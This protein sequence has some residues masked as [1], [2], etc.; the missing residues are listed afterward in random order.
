MTKAAAKESDVFKKKSSDKK[1]VVGKSVTKSAAKKSEVSKK[2]SPDKK[3]VV[4]KSVT[5]ETAKKSESSKKSS[6]KKLGSKAEALKE[7]VAGKKPAIKKAENKKL[8]KRQSKKKTAG[9]GLD[10]SLE[11]SKAWQNLKEKYEG[12][13]IVSYNMKKSFESE[14]AIKHK[15]FGLG[16]IISQYNNRLEVLFKDGRKKLISN[17]QN[18]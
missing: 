10:S 11:D 14:I 4:G 9:K 13:K 12:G 7:P 18:N 1:S 8:T 5:K 17:Y 6:D 16:F 3:P 15:E 2:K